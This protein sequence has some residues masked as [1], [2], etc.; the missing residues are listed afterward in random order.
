MEIFTFT[1][2]DKPTLSSA[3]LISVLNGPESL[4]IDHVNHR[5]YTNLGKEAAAIDLYT[6]TIV[7]QWPNGCE[8]SRGDALDEKKGFLFVSCGEGKAIVF[9]IN[10]NN[11]QLSSLVTGPGVDVISYN[12]SLSHL[13][14][15]GSK[16][17]TVSV[18]GV[19]SQGQLSLL[20][21]SQAVYRAHCVVGDDQNNMWVCDPLHG[22]LLRYKDTFPAVK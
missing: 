10:H 3:M 15:T 21:I 20:G 5:A 16:N 18:L 11:A 1:A 17:A 12:A 8:K 22:Q 14:F 19:S 2:G 9:D 13:Y 4:V 6:H 7:A